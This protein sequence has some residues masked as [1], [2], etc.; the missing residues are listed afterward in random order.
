MDFK[1]SSQKK[2][3]C[4][5]LIP[6]GKC[7]ENNFLI[8]KT[9][10]RRSVYP[11]PAPTRTSTEQNLSLFSIFFFFLFF[12]FCLLVCS[13]VYQGRDSEDIYSFIDSENSKCKCFFYG[14]EDDFK[15]KGLRDL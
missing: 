1:S 13:F 2:H 8:L 10:P 15:G 4:F 7:L 5:K 12:S 11:L 3:C 9:K 14:A 6:L